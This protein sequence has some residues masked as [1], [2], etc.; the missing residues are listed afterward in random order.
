MKKKCKDHPYYRG[1][2]VPR[3]RDKAGELCKTCLEIFSEVRATGYKE[4]RLRGANK[5]RKQV[6]LQPEQAEQVMD[7]VVEE[8]V[9]QPVEQLSVEPEAAPE[10]A[11]ECDVNEIDKWLDD[12]INDEDFDL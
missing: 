12:V 2:R 9:E 1:V 8:A 11:C 5:P 4:S 3:A 10:A 7:Q 6:E